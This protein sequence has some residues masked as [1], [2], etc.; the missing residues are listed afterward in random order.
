M[1]CDS[2]KSLLK[3]DKKGIPNH[4]IDEMITCIYN[5]SCF[6]IY[7]EMIEGLNEDEEVVFG[8]AIDLGSKLKKTKEYA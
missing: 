4:K 7:T 8:G 2:L 5:L 1:G 6:E 3:K